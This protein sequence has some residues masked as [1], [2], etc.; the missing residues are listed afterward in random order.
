MHSFFTWR[1]MKGSKN[2]VQEL[3]PWSFRGARLK[4]LFKIIEKVFVIFWSF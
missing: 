1:K 2:T 3:S 4:H